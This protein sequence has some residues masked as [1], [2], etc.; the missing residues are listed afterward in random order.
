MGTEGDILV[1]ID[2]IETELQQLTGE[3][4]QIRTRVTRTQPAPAATPQARKPLAP[5]PAIRAARML[6]SEGR[7]DDVI[8]VLALSLG[9][10]GGDP[11]G[12]AS[13]ADELEGIA[14]YR[15]RVRERAA[16][17]ARTARKRRAAAVPQRTYKDFFI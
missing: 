10:A 3:I 4:H 11:D 16:E 13:L 7:E 2:E 5:Q 9:H 15:P 6:L 8:L 17:L 1:R 12:L 14:R